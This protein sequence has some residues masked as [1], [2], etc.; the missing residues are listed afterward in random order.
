MNR[1][2]E[3]KKKHLKLFTLYHRWYN[4]PKT[5]TPLSKYNSFRSGNDFYTKRKAIYRELIKLR[6][7]RTRA[8]RNYKN[9]KRFNNFKLIF[10]KKT[11]FCPEF[12]RHFVLSY[13]N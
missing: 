11:G 2:N 3:I 5:P 12:C 13:L 7:E 6:R 10:Y 8:W 1:Y 9:E 4:N